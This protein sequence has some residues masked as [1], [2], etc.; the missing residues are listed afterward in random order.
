MRQWSN[1]ICSRFGKIVG[2]SVGSVPPIMLKLRLMYQN[3]SLA[4]GSRWRKGEKF[5]SIVYN[6]MFLQSNAAKYGSE[7]QFVA[8]SVKGHEQ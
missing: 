2:R 6:V 1:P 4:V 7:V 8:H 5:R 3:F